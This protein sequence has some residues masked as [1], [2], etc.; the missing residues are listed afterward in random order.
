MSNLPIASAVHDR[1]H[2]MVLARIFAERL[3]ALLEQ[4]DENRIYLIGDVNPDALYPLAAQF[5]VLGYKGW[6]LANTI[7][8]RRDLIRT[9]IDLH[10]YKGTPWAVKEAIRRMGFED[11]FIIE[12]VGLISLYYD[13]SWTYNGSVTYGNPED[14]EWATFSVYI[15]ASNFT[16]LIGGQYLT[17]LLALIEEYKGVRNHLVDLVF[18][19]NFED[20]MEM[21]DVSDFGNV[22][23]FE[24]FITGFTLTYDGSW[25][26]DGGHDYDQTA[27][28]LTVVSSGAPAVDPIVVEFAAGGFDEV[29]IGVTAV[30]GSI[31]WG[32]GSPVDTVVD[33]TLIYH[34]Y[35]G[36]AAQNATINFV[37]ITGL[38]VYLNENQVVSFSYLPV[39]L[40]SIS[41]NTFGGEN[42]DFSPYSN[43][44][45][46]LI[47]ASPSL[48]D[49]I[50]PENADLL[51]VNLENNALTGD[52]MN[53]ILMTLDAAG[54]ENGFC[55][56]RGNA[57]LVSGDGITAI[58]N[59]IGKGWT[60]NWDV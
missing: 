48:A 38:E 12:R 1:E 56:L 17:A 41:I 59:L 13:G 29:A 6:F 11:V 44:E 16:D 55:E 36:T 2:I 25:N 3:D 32:D 43:L 10:R 15:N 14:G 24:D 51:Y 45:Y 49:V 31:D 50:I 57:G 39:S 5:D 52:S 28:T 23:N 33:S 46:L 37:G 34:T 26:Y 42:F 60:V 22:A 8:K 58:I 40:E 27:D 47:V 19:L 20:S 9:A 4:V 53:A 35:V 54:G 18:Q 30:S 7:E 21:L